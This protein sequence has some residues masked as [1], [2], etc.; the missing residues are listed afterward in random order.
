[1]ISLITMQQFD[2]HWSLSGELAKLF[3]K[4]LSQL[5]NSP[6]MVRC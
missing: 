4:T 3:G 5:T 2:G 1:M 6:V